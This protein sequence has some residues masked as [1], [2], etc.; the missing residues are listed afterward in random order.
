[1]V[2]AAAYAVAGHAQG[3]RLFEQQPGFDSAETLYYSLITLTTV[4]YG[5]LTMRSEVTRIMSAMEAL[6][7]QIYLITAVA[8]LV[9]NLGRSRRAR[10]GSDH[11]P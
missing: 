9:G 6:L 5:D 7:G 2:F 4:G 1:M 10:R 3:D 8:L 11:V